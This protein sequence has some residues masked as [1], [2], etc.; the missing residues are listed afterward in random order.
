[1]NAKIQTYLLGGTKHEYIITA[2]NTADLG[3]KARE[4]CAAIMLNGFR[5]NSGENEFTWFGP[6]WVDK[7]KVIG[8]VYTTYPTV[9]TGT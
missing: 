7:I 4:H 9:P 1:M 5:S 8:T 3:A 2:D 6:H